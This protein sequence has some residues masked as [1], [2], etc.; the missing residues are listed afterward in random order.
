MA[1]IYGIGVGPG[2]SELLT[3]KAVK[4]IEKCEVI[5]APVAM[6]GKRSIALNIAKEYIKGD[7]EV[8]LL[9]FPMGGMEQDTKIYEAFKAV[10]EK[11]RE[12]KNV[13]FLTIG[14]PFVYSTYIY[15]LEH[16]KKAGYDAETIPGITSFSACASLAE[17]ALVIG[18]E[19]LLIIPGN[20]LNCIK[21]EKNVVIMK[22]YKKEEEILD[23]LEEKGFTYVCVKR[24]GR[25][26]QKITRDREEIINQK[27]YMSLIIAHRK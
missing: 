11:L 6:K 24:A 20:R 5:V 23:A 17:E 26:G 7:T 8:L 15:L 2:D 1:K 9:H 13:G 16:V 18:D 10:E 27:E 25:E 22:V 14:D 12:G 3:I 19:P 4:T 21:D